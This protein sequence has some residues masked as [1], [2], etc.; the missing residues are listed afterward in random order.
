MASIYCSMSGEGRGHATRMRT[1][2][3]ELRGRNQVTLFAPADA[4]QFLAPIYA[5]ASDVEVVEIPG[6]LFH[7][8]NGRLHL[9]RSVYEG[10]R[11]LGSTLGQVVDDLTERMRQ[12]PPDLVVTDFD[13]ALPRAA[14]RLGIPFVS[15]THQHFLVACDL[16]TLPLT[17]RM[18]AWSMGLVVRAHYSGQAATVVSS[19]FPATTRP[20]FEETVL[21][22]PLVRPEVRDATLDEGDYILSYLRKNTPPDVIAS[23]G[24]T[25]ERIKVYGVGARP[26]EGGL[27]FHAIDPDAFVRD[28]AG[29]RAVVCAAGNQLLGECTFLGKPALA[30]PET[31]HYE[32]L[33][34]S[35]F[36][37]QMGCGDFVPLEDMT[38]SHVTNF[39]QRL[40]D[41]RTGLEKTCLKNNGTRRVVEV[42]QETLATAG[43]DRVAV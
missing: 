37:R 39:L 36:L 1:I 9:A 5:Q 33:M 3:E 18:H 26:A 27:S 31:S 7:Y 38:G 32:Q 29:C 6:L 12:N 22:G 23:L 40:G 17:L 2:V 13:P 34:N 19:F 10:L 14:Q 24:S 16:S 41:F 20:G 15:V 4:Y 8:V 30:I 25:R 35:H 43:A 42:I 11:Y 21:V 28:L